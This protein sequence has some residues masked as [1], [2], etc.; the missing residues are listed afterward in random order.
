MSIMV[1]K[2]VSGS[3]MAAIVERM[4]EW[5][6]AQYAPKPVSA[7]ATSR[8]V[9]APV[10]GWREEKRVV[11]TNDAHQSMGKGYKPR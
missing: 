1:G 3:A 6:R 2:A 4:E 11:F 8:S 7:V 5:R 10:K 9:V